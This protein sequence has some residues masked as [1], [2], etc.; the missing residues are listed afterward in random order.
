[1]S[2]RTPP[3]PH[4]I[5]Q[6]AREVRE[7]LAPCVTRLQEHVASDPAMAGVDAAL[8]ARV[9]G[10]LYALEAYS[11]DPGALLGGLR[12][13]MTSLQRTLT[14]LQEHGVAAARE[15]AV[16]ASALSRIFPLTDALARGAAAGDSSRGERGGTES[17]IPLVPPRLVHPR[18][19][20]AEGPEPAI[21]LARAKSPPAAAPEPDAP[22]LLLERRSERRVTLNVGVGFHS[23]NNFYTGF[24]GDVSEGGLFVAT[25]DLLPIGAKVS[26]TFWLPD[27]VEV[28]VEG[29]VA[30]I[31]H[32]QPDRPPGMGIRFSH[33][34]AE[35]RSAIERFVRRREPLFHDE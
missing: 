31:R 26:L 20:E 3:S 8:L 13:A 9:V 32:P 27:D 28:T 16:V 2:L 1:M 33:L 11:D 35:A 21:P 22:V 14:A 5:L 6:V 23:E 17:A 29:E 4:S 34:S 25:Y 18:K 24:G 10:G 30:W 15:T 19:P 7:Q 12:D